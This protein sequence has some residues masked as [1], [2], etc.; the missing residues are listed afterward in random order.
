MAM[1]TYVILVS[2]YLMLSILLWCQRHQSKIDNISHVLSEVS[3]SS[4]VNI[5]SGNGL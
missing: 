1:D 4:S 3:A 2:V 5:A